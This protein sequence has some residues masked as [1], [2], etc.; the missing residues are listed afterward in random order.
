VAAVDVPVVAVVK[1]LAGV[2]VGVTELV[3]EE[4]VLTLVDV[5]EEDSIVAVAAKALIAAVTPGLF[6]NAIPGLLSLI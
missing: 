5:D 3:L 2:M 6:E 1:K 4:L